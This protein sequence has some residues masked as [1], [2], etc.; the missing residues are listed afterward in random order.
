VPLFIVTMA[1]QNVPGFAVMSTFGYRPAP[2]PVLVT[3][4]AAS[5]VAAF[6]GG[7]AI[8]LAAIT[9]AIMASPESNP[10]PARRWVATFTSGIVY[11]VLGA[12]AGLAAAVVQASP[13]IIITAV[14]GLALLGA[15]VTSITG[16]LE[17]PVHR[18]TAIGTFLV[19]ASGIAVAGIGSAF[20]GLVVGGVLMLWQRPRAAPAPAMREPGVDSVP[21]D[22][23]PMVRERDAGAE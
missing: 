13:P 4:G 5:I 22:P 15:L 1:G 2:R 18:I 7:H 3:S 21:V 8:N 14:A 10:D 12:G 20:W 9:A 16:A 11:L 23:A 17:V 6:A 19:T